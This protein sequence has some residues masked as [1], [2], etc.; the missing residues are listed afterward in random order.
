MPGNGSAQLR[1]IA[2]QLK[3]AGDRGLR[4]ELMRGLRA[5]AAPLIPLVA[6]AARRQLPKRGGLNEQVA[7]QKVKVSVRTGAATAGVRLTTTAPDTKQTDSGYVRHP[8]FGHKDRPWVVQQI[9]R[10]AG[11][12]S[13][14]LASAAPVVTPALIAQMRVV[15]ARIQG[16]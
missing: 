12:W 15:E 10:A 11:W 2:V 13:D 3:V 9:P 6:D 4:L 16:R 1:A 7:A 8:V 14:T 5:G